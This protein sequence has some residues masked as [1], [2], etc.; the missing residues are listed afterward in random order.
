MSDAERVTFSE[1]A[2]RMYES[3]TSEERKLTG[4]W[5]VVEQAFGIECDVGRGDREARPGPMLW[6]VRW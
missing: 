5:A 6:K 1:V 2:R 4:L 3:A